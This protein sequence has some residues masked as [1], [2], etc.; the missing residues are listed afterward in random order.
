MQVHKIIP[1]EIDF[2]DTFPKYLVSTD[3]ADLILIPQ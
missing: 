3:H 2:I 1:D